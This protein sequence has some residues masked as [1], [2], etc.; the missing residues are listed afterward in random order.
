MLSVGICDKKFYEQC[1]REIIYKKNNLKFFEFILC[2]HKLNY[3]KFDQNFLKYKF[4][5][6]I[7]RRND[8]DYLEQCDID[9]FFE[10]M[11]GKKVFDQESFNKITG[12]LL[13]RYKDQYPNENGLN[14]WKLSM[15][16]EHFFEIKI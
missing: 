10:L 3:L 9:R 14:V 7:T 16:L 8:S 4:L 1:I 12:K 5:L 2:F 6:L 11:K 15:V 13:D